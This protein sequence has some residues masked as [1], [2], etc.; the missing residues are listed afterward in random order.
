[1]QNL[2]VY[3]AAFFDVF[4]LVDAINARAPTWNLLGFIDDT[5]E[6]QGTTIR[7]L[8]VIGGCDALSDTRARG[9]YVLNNVTGHWERTRTVA[10]RIDTAGLEPARLVHPSIDLNRVEMGRGGL[11]SDGSVIGGF[12]RIGDHVT[13]RLGATISHDVTIGDYVFVGPGA[14]L[15]GYC[16]LET[17][18]FIGAGATVMMNRT[19]GCGAVVGAGATVTRDVPAHCTVAGVPARGID[20]G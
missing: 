16:V 20:R 17:G 15:G 18:A 11:V 5:A 14:T 3:G 2:L 19:V 1:M 8:E 4:K 7:G 10:G 9:A 13:V 6:L 12:T